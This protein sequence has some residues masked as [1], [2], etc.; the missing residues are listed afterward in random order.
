MP[1]LSAEAVAK[2]YTQ[3]EAPVIAVREVNLS[4]EKGEFVALTGP[5]GC[6]KSTLLHLCG[7]MDYPTRGR[8]WLDGTDL[9]SLDEGRLTRV[10]R[11]QVGFVFQSFNLL[12]TANARTRCSE[13]RETGSVADRM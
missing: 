12:P 11:R 4:L 8:I 2:T 5:S 13:P 1:V 7:G 6:G 3:G 10:R 9:G